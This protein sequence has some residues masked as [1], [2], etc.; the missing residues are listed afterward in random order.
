MKTENIY[1]STGESGL[2]YKLRA[3]CERTDIK[4]I[5]VIPVSYIHSEKGMELSDVLIIY[6]DI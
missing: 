4:I 2:F 6:D 1:L 5:S 3:F